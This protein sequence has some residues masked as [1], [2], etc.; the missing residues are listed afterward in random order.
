M[1]NMISLT[2]LW[3]ALKALGDRRRELRAAKNAGVIAETNQIC[4]E[5]NEQLRWYHRKGWRK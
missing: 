5:L 1:A 4:A 3:V 2:A